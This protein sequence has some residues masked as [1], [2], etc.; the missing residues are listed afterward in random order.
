MD[1]KQQL[2]RL[3]NRADETRRRVAELD[4]RQTEATSE[5]DA[6]EYDLKRLVEEIRSLL[7]DDPRPVSAAPEPAV[8]Q[9]SR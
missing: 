1:I 2:Q 6:A 5:L 3:V 8:A 9:R 7:P 4:S